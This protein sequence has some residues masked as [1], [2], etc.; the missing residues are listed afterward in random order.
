[1]TPRRRLTYAE[2]HDHSFSLNYCISFAMERWAKVTLSRI[3]PLGIVE[4]RE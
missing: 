3:A 4:P 2:P 1:M